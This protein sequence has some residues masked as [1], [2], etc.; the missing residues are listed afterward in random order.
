MHIEKHSSLVSSI[1]GMVQNTRW[2]RINLAFGQSR[3]HM[4]MGSLPSLTIPR[5]N[6]ALGMGV[7]HGLIV[8]PHGFVMQLLMPLNLE[9]HMMVYTGILQPVKGP[10]LVP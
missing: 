8:F 10:L 1:T 9:L 7:E 4:S 2:R 6:F 5:L 3:F